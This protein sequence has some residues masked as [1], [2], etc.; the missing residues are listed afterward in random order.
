MNRISVFVLTAAM[1]ATGL[2][3]GLL[4]GASPAGAGAYTPIAPVGDLVKLQADHVKV[5]GELAS[6]KPKKRR[7]WSKI[8]NHAWIIAETANLLTLRKDKSGELPKQAAKVVKA[9]S[10][11][12]KAAKKKDFSNVP[13]YVKTIT[14]G[15]GAMAKLAKAGE[16]KP[17][18]ASG[19]K[20]IAPVDEFMEVN[21]DCYD[22]VEELAKSGLSD[23]KAYAEV[24]HCGW[25]LAETGS[26][27]LLSEEYGEKED[28]QK[29]SKEMRD[30]GKRL[31]AEAKKK[32]AAAIGKTLK[33]LDANCVACHDEYQ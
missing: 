5:L 26:L 4:R 16:S 33:A 24:T 20:P 25:L 19:F 10:A 23:A 14:D 2:G 17:A 32:D 15:S 6:K 8:R 31:I 18:P 27:L 3:M 1:A 28:W 11:L 30:L 29:W 12:G 9:A 13:E 21:Q 22:K 7:T